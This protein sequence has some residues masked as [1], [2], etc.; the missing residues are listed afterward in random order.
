MI[1]LAG[2]SYSLSFRS[3]LS[4]RLLTFWS[5]RPPRTCRSPV[6]V[7][8]KDCHFATGVQHVLCLSC[9]FRAGPMHPIT[10]VK[11]DALLLLSGLANLLQRSIACSV[12]LTTETCVSEAALFHAFIISRFPT[13]CFVS[14]SLGS[15]T[16][17]WGT[18]H[19]L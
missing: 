2:L 17:E 9:T 11:A 5:V 15:D 10:A 8:R 4:R 19:D 16:H 13:C 1:I 14:R 6:P 7:A 18:L 3:S 12:Q